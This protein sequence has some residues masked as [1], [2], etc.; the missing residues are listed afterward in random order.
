[1]QTY[2]IKEND[3]F[4]VRSIGSEEAIAIL[5]GSAVTNAVN[6]VNDIIINAVIL[7]V[8]DAV[9]AA[10]IGSMVEAHLGTMDMANVIDEALG[11]AIQDYDFE[12]AIDNAID[13]ADINT[14]VKEKVTDH[15]D[16]LDIKISLD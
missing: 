13:D 15:L 11:E 1:M 8:N 7:R 12:N 6:K 4:I 9:S 16:D 3:E 10:N 5:V 2:Y 14:L